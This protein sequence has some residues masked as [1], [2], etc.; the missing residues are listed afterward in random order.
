MLNQ[1]TFKRKLNPI[2]ERRPWSLLEKNP[3]SAKLMYI[4]LHTFPWPTTLCFYGYQD[5]TRSKV[6]GN[7][8]VNA[9]HAFHRFN[10]LYHVKRGRP[11]KRVYGI[12]EDE[13]NLSRLSVIQQKGTF[14]STGTQAHTRIHTPIQSNTHIH[15]HALRHSHACTHAQRHMHTYTHAHTCEI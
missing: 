12:L 2:K 14:A 10:R 6:T 8:L 3:V 9:L 4:Y 13:A 7:F 11:S 15:M 1:E 5:G